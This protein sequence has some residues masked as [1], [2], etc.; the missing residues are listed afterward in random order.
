MKVCTKS[1]FICDAN[2]RKKQE[3]KKV[4]KNPFHSNLSQEWGTP[5]IVLD[6]VREVFGGGIDL[7][8]ASSAEANKYVG[9]A[10]VFTKE[11]NGPVNRLWWG[12]VFVNPPS[13]RPDRKSLS[14][15]EQFWEV[16]KGNLKNIDQGIYLGYN[17]ELLRMCD[18]ILQFP[19]CVPDKRLKFVPLAG[20]KAG[21]PQHGNFITYVPGTVDR[22]DMFLNAFSKIGA[23]KR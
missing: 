5:E 6:A 3:S 9:A 7:D 15:P 18:G 4:V 23:V 13:G 8:P 12:D 19:I 11:D 16:M 10:R 22:T 17:L 21:S 20:Q 2:R 1:C 14:L